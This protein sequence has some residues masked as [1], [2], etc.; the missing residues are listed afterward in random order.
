MR[1]LALVIAS[2]VFSAAS[3]QAMA[4]CPYKQHIAQADAQKGQD[5]AKLP[6]TE[7]SRG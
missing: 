3:F 1:A 5:A 2:L 6:S 7:Q 4:A